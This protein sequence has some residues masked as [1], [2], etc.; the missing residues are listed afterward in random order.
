MSFAQRGPEE[1]RALED[2]DGRTY[3]NHSR[4]H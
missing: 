1:I 4:T 3:D 2:L